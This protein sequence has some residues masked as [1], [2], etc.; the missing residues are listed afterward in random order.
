MPLSPDVF[1]FSA[2]DWELLC[3]LARLME[4][5]GLR[6]EDVFSVNALLVSLWEPF[7]EEELVLRDISLG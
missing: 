4:E 1:S 3:E 6:R 5:G 2:L 7:L